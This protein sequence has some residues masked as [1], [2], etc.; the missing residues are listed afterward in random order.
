M[1]RLT[2]DFYHDVVCG[3]CFNLSPRLHRLAEE[4]GLKV[5]HRSFVLQDSPAQMVAVFGSMQQAKAVILGHWVACRAASD[6]PDAFNI[7]D[8]RT[9]RFDYPHGLPAALACKTAERLAGQAGHGR[10]FD[11]LQRAHISQ[12]RNVADPGVIAAVAAE[13]GFDAVEFGRV[14]GQDATR[15]AVEADR[16]LARRHQ[17]AS[18]PTVIVEETGARLVNGPMA[19]LR[20]QIRA[21]LRLAEV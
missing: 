15:S 14:M 12:A 16:K 7:E 21:N 10:L 18:V 9:A 20:A 4:F 13:A 2:L 19:D 3:W 11:A 8:M 17:V 5:R 1:T 6:R